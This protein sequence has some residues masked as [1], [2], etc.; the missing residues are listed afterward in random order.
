MMTAVLVRNFYFTVPMPSIFN[1]LGSP[2]NLWFEKVIIVPI[3]SF[4]S[5]EMARLSLVSSITEKLSFTEF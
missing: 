5:N 1:P 4:L 2:P 3:E